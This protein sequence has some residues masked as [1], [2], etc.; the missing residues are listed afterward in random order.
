MC[1][2]A[3]SA[4][5]LCFS[6]VLVLLSNHDSR[7]VPSMSREE[8]NYTPVLGA[9]GFEFPEALVALA[10]LNKRVVIV[11]A[12]SA[13]YQISHCCCSIVRSI[14]SAVPFPRLSCLS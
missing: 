7:Q 3:G 12:F 8:Y 9:G 11:W 5:F 2:H 14:H 4:A 6:L 10:F 1:K 13:T